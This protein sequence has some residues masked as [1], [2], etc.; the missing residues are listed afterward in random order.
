VVPAQGFLVI[1]LDDTLSPDT[2]LHFPFK[3]SGDGENFYLTNQAGK[4]AKKLTIPADPTGTNVNSPDVSYGAYPNGSTTFGWCSSP[5]PKASN[6][7]D[8]SGAR[9][10]G[11]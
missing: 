2:P 9:D 1:W 5:T 4:I 7:A 6:G 10:A 3:L 11:P 8:C